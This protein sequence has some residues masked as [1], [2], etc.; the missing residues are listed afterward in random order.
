MTNEQVRLLF[1]NKDTRLKHCYFY[2][3]QYARGRRLTAV[4]T[5]SGGHV[6]RGMSCKHI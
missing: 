1:C 6:L 3:A 4:K 2:S 5:K